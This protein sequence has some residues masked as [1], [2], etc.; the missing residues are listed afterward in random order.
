MLEAVKAYNSRSEEQKD[1]SFTTFCK[2][3][4]KNHAAE[5]IGMRTQR[6]RNEALNCIHS[7]L[8]EPLTNKDGDSSE[9]IGTT[10]PDP[11]AEQPFRN[12]EQA[13][14]YR[15]IRIAV[16]NTLKEESREHQVLK[17]RYYEGM[18]LKE[19]GEV[20]GLSIERIRQ[21]EK[22]AMRQLR[23][24][25]EF[26]ELTEVSFYRHVSVDS[27]RRTHISAV[28]AVAEERERKRRCIVFLRG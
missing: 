25:R 26:K 23:N 15:S 8:D 4:F 17:C 16:A 3:P 5:L 19:T 22:A 11:K 20:F 12:I 27:F 1:Y 6:E 28:E 7:S 10:T 2:F 21:L 18:T 24:S 9:T 14:Y 13:D